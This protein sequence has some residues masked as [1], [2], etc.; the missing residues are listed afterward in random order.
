MVFI[1]LPL[2]LRAFRGFRGVYSKSMRQET[3]QGAYKAIIRQSQ[4]AD[5]ATSLRADSHARMARL[6]G[7]PQ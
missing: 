5:Q 7:K 2:F 1:L 4:S 3:Y 6:T